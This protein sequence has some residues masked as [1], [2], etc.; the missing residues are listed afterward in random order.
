MVNHNA[1]FQKHPYPPSGRFW[2][3][4][5]A[6]P[7]PSEFLMTFHDVGIDIFWTRTLNRDH[8]A[9]K[10]VACVSTRNLLFPWA[11][12]GIKL[13]LGNSLGKQSH[14]IRVMVSGK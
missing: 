14:G 12:Q 7:S 4:C 11:F 2:F 10:P 9:G 5:S 13:W 1:L 8:I 3:E 6:H